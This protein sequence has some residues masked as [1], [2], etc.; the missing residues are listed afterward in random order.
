MR[1]HW[2][3]ELN[4]SLVG[5]EVT[6]AGWVQRRRD[7]GSL[8]FIDLRDRSGLAQL[9]F[10]KDSSA[11]NLAEELRSEYV[12][13]AKGLVAKRSPENF[14]P[15]LATGEIELKVY[16]LKIYNRSYNPPFYI[17]DGLNVEESLRLKYRY[18]DLRR[19]EMM[20]RLVQRHRAV[21]VIRD[22]L[23]GEGFLEIE[24]PMLTRSTPEGARDFLV[25]CRLHPGSFYALPQSP[26]LFK[27]LLMV[28][29]VERYFQIAR[30]FRDEDLR[31]DRQPEFTQIDL[32]ASFYRQDLLF[33]LIEGV[34]AALWEEL[35]GFKL[36]RPFLRLAYREAMDRFGSDK[37]DLRLPGELVDLT[38][39]AGKSS[40]KVFQDAVNSG[41]VVKGWRLAGGG[42]FSRKDLDDVIEFARGQ[43]AKG[44]VW[45]IRESKGWRS[46]VAKFFDQELLSEIGER[47]KALP[48]DLLLMAADRW[49]ICCTVLGQLR[50]HLG[51]PPEGNKPHFLWVV[52]FPL[53]QSE[54][55][56]YASS[57]HPFTAPREEDLPFLET[58]PLAV[59][60]QAYDLVLNGVELGSGSARIYRR[61]IQ[62]RIFKILGLSSQEAVDKFGF[63]LEA[64]EYGA[65]PHMGIALGLDRLVAMITGDESIRQVIAFPKTAGA[66]C[67]VTGAP[68]AVSPEQLSELKIAVKTDG[69]KTGQTPSKPR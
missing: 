16:E 19:P 55:Q 22:F 6:L 41:E 65:P 36:T 52:D 37:P 27:Q 68:A 25:P 33:D 54:E 53:F 28:A 12:I 45:M 38:D 34:M 2:C 21:K 23:H 29:G 57:H 62:E 9:V 64:F 67:L 3:G 60:S 46:P 32:E 47:T 50:L 58:R 4:R 13:M 42:S 7:H 44:L 39:L 30:C 8:I 51:S 5:R 14:N 48:G 11:F 18:L 61:D 59:R 40:F 56:G 31:A 26:Q 24:T 35:S 66:A 49:E 15:R 43:G 20:Q 1:T 69:R 10:D 17:E 63:L